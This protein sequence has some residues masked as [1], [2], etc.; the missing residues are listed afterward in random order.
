MGV[1]DNVPRPRGS[2]RIDRRR[3]LKYGGA[4]I[5][6]VA[7]GGLWRIDEIVAAPPS[8]NPQ[9]AGRT[10]GPKP[11]LTA[12]LR[13]REDQLAL[14]MEFYNLVLDTSGQNPVLVRKNA[15]KDAHVVVVF[16]P[17]HVMEEALYEFDPS[18]QTGVDPPPNQ[19]GP[20][21]TSSDPAPPPPLGSRLAGASRLA[22]RIPPNKPSIPFDTEGLLEWEDW[23]PSVLPVA[24]GSLEI[25]P[26]GREATPELRAPGALDTAIE[27]PWWLVLSPHVQTGWNHAPVQV[28]RNG[29]TE[30][31]HTRLGG[32]APDGPVDEADAARM[33]VRAVWTRDPE[34][35]D[36]LS[37]PANFPP[38][39]GED[40][41]PF[42]PIGMP[43]RTPL[44]PRDRYDLV[45]STSDYEHNVSDLGYLPLPAQVDRLMLTPLG[46]WL[47]LHGEWEA[48]PG[49]GRSGTS[50]QSWRHHAT[51]GRDHYVRIVRSGFLFPFG[52]GASLIKVTE[53]KFRTI[54]SGGRGDPKRRV[55][56][57]F[58]R[59][60]IVVRQRRVVFGGQFQPAAGRAFPFTRVEAKTLITPN[61]DPPGSH[62][63]D[64]SEPSF[65]NKTQAFVPRVGGTPFR[66][67]LVGPD[68][69][70][71]RIDLNAAVVFIDGTKATTTGPM[72]EIGGYYDGRPV[73]SPERAI[74][75]QGTK[76]AVAPVEPGEAPG[77]TDL[78]IRRFTLGAEP[79]TTTDD[80]ALEGAMQ[81]AFFPTMAEA[82]IRLA[83][84]EATVGTSL[85]TPPVVVY[86]QGYV[87]LDFAG[88]GKGEVFVRLKDT[89]NPT[90]LDF[91]GNQAGDRSGGVITP[92]LGVTA[93]SR[94]AGTVGGNPDTFQSGQFDP[95]DF[96]G[97]LDATLLGDITL[98]DVIELVTGGDFDLADPAKKD[99]VIQ[100]NTRDEPN[101]IVTELRWRPALKDVGDL[102][103]ASLGSTPASLDLDATITTPKQN[104]QGS[105]FVV[106]GDLRHFQ[107]G[108]LPGARFILVQFDRLRFQSETGKKTDVDVE[109]A[110]VLFDG[111]LKFVNQLK[112]YLTF[113]SGGFSIEL[114]PTHLDAGFQLPLPNITVGVFSLSNI[115][116]AAGATIPFTGKPVRFRFGF[117]T[118]EDPFLLSVMIFGGGGFFELA[119]GPD[120]V[121]AFQAAL[122]FG[123]MASLDFGVASGSVSVTA[124]IYLAIGIENPPDN[125]DGAAELTGFIKIKGEVEVLGIITVSVLMKASFTY[126]PS[127]EK[128]IVKAVIVV[129]IDVL[130]FSGSVEVEYEKKFG[131]SN[132]PTFGESL[133][134]ADW[135]AYA[136]AF[137]PIGV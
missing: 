86:D 79:P 111:P 71:R 59:Y 116:F 126:I 36:Y 47:D 123:V 121:E 120:G 2:H 75:L 44:S 97:A 7:A 129:E 113:S 122:E 89:N 60:F 53:R 66:F 24:R 84:A 137:A 78:E 52:F 110:E 26:I 76:V 37:D 35:P 73:D 87:D 19:D 125:P 32:K 67:H 135:E 88:A 90:N 130:L 27:L 91:G 10:Q 118:Q 15:N 82:Q 133:A 48:E 131:G 22:F 96:F 43:F 28:T 107:V 62:V 70:G 54:G 112:D 3:F 103:I 94:R 42:H 136:D 105:T 56:Y 106:V 21:P 117:S 108:L 13:R 55:A 18:V 8:G 114:L 50:L 69:V 39:D 81:P 25:Q 95:A 51:M 83:A 20:D 33:T 29:R 119:L 92:S 93:L 41:E 124:G 1:A 57:L 12:V 128:A 31:W 102:F 40:F 6:A 63:D 98:Q 64:P 11:S 68:R 99:R 115:T 46:A 58:Q 45:V 77:A 104:P 72:A 9:Q 74:D 17:Q 109:I 4:S 30:L 101:A 14:V 23:I 127:T 65:P 5:A 134:P 61:L 85:G 132:D 49:N 16:P 38:P 80:A 100:L 34:F